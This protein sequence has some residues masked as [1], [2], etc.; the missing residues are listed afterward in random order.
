M[1]KNILE[2]SKNTRC[3]WVFLLVLSFFSSCKEE[4]IQ[5]TPEKVSLYTIVKSDPV[6]FSLL[7]AAIEKAGLVNY[8]E[9]NN[10]L[11]LLA[12]SDEAFANAGL[13]LTVINASQP[14]QL[15]S[16]IE[17]HI[18]NKA[19]LVN[20]AFTSGN[21]T[22]VNNATVVLSKSFKKFAA[23][24]ADI[25]NANKVATNGV[26]HVI[27]AVLKSD[28]DKSIYEKILANTNLSFLGVAI[29]RASEGSKNLVTD[30]SNAA[31]NYTLF[32]PTNAAFIAAGFPD[33]ARIKTTNPE[34][35]ANILNYHLLN[36]RK[37]TIDMVDTLGI[38]ALNQ[39]LLFLD[40]RVINPTRVSYTR[41]LVNGVSFDRANANIIAT[42]GVL[43]IINEAFTPPTQTLNQI[44]S[45]NTNLSFLA[46]A[47][48][49]GSQG[50]TNYSNILN[51]SVSYSIAAPT[52]AAFMAA[53]Y[54]DINAINN[55]SPAVMASILSSHIFSG[56]RFLYQF[57]NGTQTQSLGNQSFNVTVVNSSGVVSLTGANNTVAVPLVKS[58]NFIANNGLLY[59]V[60]QLLRP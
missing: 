24:G 32:A 51:E 28:E 34:V 45:S 35:L 16:I 30:L 5:N 40:T 12:P 52:N 56:Y 53:G 14:E 6:N 36:T 27:N 25:T 8:L 41:A 7:K 22:A 26:L 10:D 23:N 59:T 4:S 18:L 38:P 55:A 1:M 43:H 49:R 54:A 3:F 39:K 44:I 37:Y 31:N 19:V 29:R 15:K 50:V 47:I 11:T 42:N 60:N 58:S 57:R 48:I 17:Y 9:S 46:A 13:T 20:E 33:S 21:Q 2:I